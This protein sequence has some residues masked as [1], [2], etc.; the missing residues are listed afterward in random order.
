MAGREVSLEDR[1]V[2][3]R[4][5]NCKR[6]LVAKGVWLEGR[7]G[8]KGDVAGI[9]TWLEENDLGVEMWLEG[10]CGLKKEVRLEERFRVVVWLEDRFRRC[11]SKEGILWSHVWLEGT[12]GYK[13]TVLQG[14]NGS[15]TGV[16]AMLLEGR[17]G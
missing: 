10:R 3:G 2:V 8:W 6:G 1:D 12:R 5:S 16:G 11:V 15:N 7:C 14:R 13:G 4:R 17:C 9:E